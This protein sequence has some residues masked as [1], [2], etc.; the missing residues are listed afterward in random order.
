MIP[1]DLSA[2]VLFF[3]VRHH[4]PVCS[5][6]LLRA[7]EEYRPE[8]I[9]IEGPEDASGLIPVLTGE[10]TELPA[11]I[12]YFYKDKKKL[13]SEEEEDYRC[14]Y[15]FQYSS[16]EYNAMKAAEDLSIEAR[17]IDLPYCEILINTEGGKGLRREEGQSY[18]DDGRLTAGDYY[19][20]LCEKTQ[21]RSF[22]EF[23]EK[24]FEIAGLH[25]EPREFVR[26]MN[27]YCSLVRSGTSQRELE[28]D[29]TLV[30][31][32]CMAANIKAAMQ[33]YSRVLVV[34][35]GFH[36]PG[37]RELIK[38]DSIPQV[39]R[40]KIPEGC[41]GCFP[42]AYS[43]EAADALHGY[44]SG[45]KYPYFC[46]R[47]IKR[48]IKDNTPDGIYRDEALTLLIKTARAA[49]EQDIPVSVADVEAA[50]S[51]MTGL[52]SLR[53]MRECGMAEAVDAVTSAYIK[54]EKNVSSAVPLDILRKLATGDG[55]G[56]IGDKA[57]TPPLIADFEKQCALFKLKHDTAVPQ[58]LECGLFTG[59]KGLKLSRFLHRM[60]FL[61][62]GFCVCEKGPDLHG[63]TD[64]SRVREI[65]KYKRT[66]AVDA[67]LIDRT[68]DG[69][70]I[71]EACTNIASKQMQTQDRLADAAH[72][73]V[74]CFLMGI[75]IDGEREQLL[76]T[77]AS[78]GDFFSV[79]EALEHF[80]TLYELKKLYEYEDSLMLPLLASCFDKLT[81]ILPL[82]AC[83]PDDRADRLCS[84]MKQL[85]ALTDTLLTDRRGM[86]TQSLLEL[87]E[88]PQKHPAVHGAAMGLLCAIEPDIQKD[89]ETVMRGY[90]NGTLPVRKQG[91]EYL[92]GLFSTARDIVF[93]QNDFLLMTDELLTSMSKDDF[94]EILPPLRLAFSYFTPQE[95]AETAENIARL[96]STDSDSLLYG[97]V[98]D[99][100]LFAF[101]QKLDREIMKELGR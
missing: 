18:S 32:Q 56:R 27:T 101:G 54:G 21:V 91:A 33:Q 79:G 11:A 7:A 23:W 45:M 82:M 83:V 58:E 44:S 84:V 99:E 15:P 57:H 92:K 42:A 53:G 37:L 59:S 71:E 29:G 51:L 55:V 100:E 73:A 89:A 67:F 85:F 74:D 77:A 60:D 6:Q 50:H 24:Y 28:A 13:I 38:Q 95:I 46:D 20:R 90:L 30:R 43:Y 75:S 61:G 97:E 80:R 14:Y 76:R 72:T 17:F 49:A 81:L 94:M 52:A 35:G 70:T 48:L 31:E 62:T 22:D 2:P 86:F 41:T 64:R 19:K 25:M 34:T 65:W 96:Y 3:P 87:T 36:T 26:V 40:H 93:S 66:P 10:G 68:T 39:K 98:I 12:Y 47:V 4:S 88:Q 16:P 8:I 69:F 78:D 9:L 63:S 5:W 1:C